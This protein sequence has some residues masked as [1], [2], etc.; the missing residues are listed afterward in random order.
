MRRLVGPVA[1][2]VVCVASCGNATP[3]SGPQGTAFVSG[4]IGDVEFTPEDAIAAYDPSA[5]PGQP[6]VEVLITNMTG[7]CGFGSQGVLPTNF[8]A[9][10]LFVGSAVPGTYAYVLSN[11][12]SPPSG[13]SGLSPL[14]GLYVAHSDNAE[15][16]M[17]GG[18]I[19]LGTV[20]AENISGS[21]DI[22]FINTGEHLL[23]TFSAPVC[24]TALR[25]VLS[26]ISNSTYH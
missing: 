18:T 15:E 26:A 7:T 10:A 11:H 24:G 22:T 2:A 19:I 3:G 12:P 9:V 14:N 6:R 5:Q 17:A 21:F 4:T 23:G 13:V 1:A 25:N 8:A 16:P 20:N